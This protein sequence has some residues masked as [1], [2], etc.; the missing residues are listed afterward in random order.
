MES[1]NTPQGSVWHRVA[2]SDRSLRKN[3][4]VRA[5]FDDLTEELFR[6]RYRPGAG[7]IGASQQSYV[8]LGAY[9]N[10]PVFVDADPERAGL[11][12][13]HV[14]LAETFF[15]DNHAG[16]IDTMYRA[17][18]LTARQA[19]QEYGD[20][21]PEGIKTAA[22]SNRSE[23]KFE[24]LHVVL[25]NS[26]RDPVRVDAEGMAFRSLHI[27]L[28]EGN[29]LLR[30]GGYRSFPYA[31]AR[32]TQAP[33]ETYGR[34]PAQTV[35]SAI[36]LLNQQKKTIIKQ[37]HRVVDP[38]LLA[39]DD[40]VLDGFS[41]KAGA[42]NRGGVNADG[43]ALVQTL[44]TGNLSVG[45][46]MM[47]MERQVINDAFLVTL[48]QILVDTPQ[49]TATEVLERAR[50]KG[51]LLAPVSGRLQADFYGPM[52]EREIDL[53]EQQGLMPEA[54][55]ILREAAAE[56]KIEYDSPMTRMAR[57]EGAAGFT[58][59]AA[60]VFD[61]VKLT[62]D[63][64]PLDHFD[65]DAAVPELMDIQAVPVRWTRDLEAVQAIRAQRAEQA[66]QKLMLENA[67]GL[68]AG[69]GALGKASEQM[70]GNPGAIQ[71]A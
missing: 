63:P 6:Q 2:A 47:D 69:V 28:T 38:V 46:K 23:D 26:D 10:G 48:F 49:M 7:F 52:I 70:G 39:Y 42:L 9:G 62:G 55:P 8:G 13:K 17:F 57:S 53:L 51:M 45:D 60:Q 54:P 31:V 65:I 18:R 66:Q 44:P 41:L 68:A 61:F 29:K 37:A 30:A 71:G 3:R 40:G 19:L 35:L 12:Y 56:Y 58:R 14:H 43:R 11:R 15:V 59:A 32:Y 34:G 21:L 24:F 16:V 4:A 50:E 1:I 27:A 67:A 25:P 22:T 64:A 33:G 5:F 20:A 36:K